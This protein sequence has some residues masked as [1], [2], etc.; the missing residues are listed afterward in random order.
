M[1]GVISKEF[2]HFDLDSEWLYTFV[3]IRRAS[4]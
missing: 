4:I 2:V 3:A 1:G